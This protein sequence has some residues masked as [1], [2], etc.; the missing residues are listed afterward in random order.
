MGTFAD[1]GIAASVGYEVGTPAY[2]DPT[3]DPENQLPLTTDELAII[4]ANTQSKT[5]AGFFWEL[6]K[7]AD[8]SAQEA[9]PT[10]VAQ[11]VCVAVLGSQEPRCQGT[12]PAYP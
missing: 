6:Y 12:I 1:A 5:N 3:H 9:T 7:T 11:S 8:A 2:P 4:V 10:Q